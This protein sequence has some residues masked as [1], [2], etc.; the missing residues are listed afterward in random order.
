MGEHLCLSVSLNMSMCKG[1]GGVGDIYLLP[2]SKSP[3]NIQS[4]SPICIHVERLR[5]RF[6]ALSLSFMEH[7]KKVG[8]PQQVVTFCCFQMNLFNPLSS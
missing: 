4:S 6:S 2:W 5:G 1:S 8:A 7:K 3:V